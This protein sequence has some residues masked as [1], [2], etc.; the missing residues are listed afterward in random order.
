MAFHCLPNISIRD[1]H[2]N[3]AFVFLCL[4]FSYDSKFQWRLIHSSG[5]FRFLVELEALVP[6]GNA[7][8]VRCSVAHHALSVSFF[9]A[10]CYH[11]DVITPVAIIKE[12]HLVV[13]N[14]GYL[15][16]AG[17]MR[18]CLV[19]AE[20]RKWGRIIACEKKRDRASGENLLV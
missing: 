3:R 9:A 19:A 14:P 7:E 17:K 13:G 20:R 4:L 11:S 15:L 8:S 10:P 1:A 2:E 6:I 12:Q 5:R 18:L 16:N